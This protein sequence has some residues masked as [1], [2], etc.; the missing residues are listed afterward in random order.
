MHTILKFPFV[1]EH[2][3]GMTDAQFLVV[4]LIGFVL[5]I[6]LF[7]KWVIPTFVQ[8]HLDSRRTAIAEAQQ[9]VEQTHNETQDMQADYRRR[10]EGIHHETQRRIEEAVRE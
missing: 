1:L 3:E 5:L 2:P 7:V 9:Q 10:L 6:W 4:R 8:P